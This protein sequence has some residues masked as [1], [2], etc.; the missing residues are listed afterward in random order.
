MTAFTRVVDRAF[1]EAI[2][3]GA[4]SNIDGDV[5]AEFELPAGFGDC[6]L[7]E[8]SAVVTSI[9]TLVALTN[10]AGPT[11]RLLDGPSGNIVDVAFT[12]RWNL[13]LA[14][15]VSCRA[16]PD[17]VQFWRE[18]ETLRVSFPEIDSNAVPTADLNVA[19]KVRRLRPLLNDAPDPQDQHF[20]LT[21]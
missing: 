12:R 10:L 20:F 2:L 19:V 13:M 8:A 11:F 18:Q 9:A 6:A 3:N 1:D 15:S 14:D 17:Q 16:G 7:M 5:N 21:S 4:V